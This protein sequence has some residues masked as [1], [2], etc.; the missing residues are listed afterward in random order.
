M[1]HL[2]RIEVFTKVKD[3]YLQLV[4]AV[5]WK[6]TGDRQLFEEAMQY[7]LLGMWQ[8]VEKLDSDKAPFY[9][10][11]IALSANSKAW[12]N[13][14]GKNGDQV[15]EWAAVDGSPDDKVGQQETLDVVR[16]A[17]AGLPEN[18][19]K[20]LVMRYLEQKEYQEIA[21]SLGCS[22][23]ASRSHV[24]KALATLR[25]RLCGTADRE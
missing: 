22:E 21:R 23:V 17:I 6:L 9:I 16:R 13:R 8:Y 3:Q 15:P 4:T 1:E 5:L 24:C 20:A 18:Q 14:V 25:S 11:R 2:R 19:S 10:Y 12:H 7:T